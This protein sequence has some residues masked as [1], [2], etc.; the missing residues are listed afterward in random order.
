MAALAAL[1]VYLSRVG[2]DKAD[3]LASVIGLFVALVGLGVAVYGLFAERRRGGGGVRQRAKA[4]GRGRVI[5]AGRDINTGQSRSRGSNDDAAGSGATSDEARPVR[6]Q[7][8]AA[9]DGRV[10]QAGRDIGKR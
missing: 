4:T 8:T 6:Q 10:D 9:E 1:G 5:Q 2:L 7:A 3:K